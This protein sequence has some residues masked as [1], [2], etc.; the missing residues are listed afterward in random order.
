MSK[1]TIF[2]NRMPANDTDNT[3]AYGV[4]D[5]V[6]TH[7]DRNEEDEESGY[8]DQISIEVDD[9]GKFGSSEIVG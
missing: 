1:K 7:V 6:L 9:N 2:V 4:D 3:V 8:S 5:R